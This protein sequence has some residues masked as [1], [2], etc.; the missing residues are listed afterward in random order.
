MA[1]KDW[2]SVGIHNDIVNAID[3]FLQTSD[4]KNL[5]L[6]SRQ[7]FINSLAKQFLE[8]YGKTKGKELLK[9]AKEVDLF[10][11]AEPKK[12]R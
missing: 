4:A 10:D 6:K 5:E 9:K 8:K 7:D 1:R 3:T 11:I 2:I 12:K